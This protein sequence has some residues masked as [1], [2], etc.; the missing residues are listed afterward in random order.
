M[1]DGTIDGIIIPFFSSA[2]LSLSFSIVTIRTCFSAYKFSGQNLVPLFFLKKVCVEKDPNSAMS[3]RL[4]WKKS[5][6]LPP[7]F[8]KVRFPLNSKTG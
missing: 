4:G 1:L 6:F 3:A 7:T 5:T 8:T 2:E